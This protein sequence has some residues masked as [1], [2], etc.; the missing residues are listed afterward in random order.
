M[1][2]QTGAQFF[3]FVWIR[4]VLYGLIDVLY[5]LI[6]ISFCIM[7]HNTFSF[8]IFAYFQLFFY[9]C[10]HEKDFVFYHFV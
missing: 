2:G 7:L 10:D 9:L 5:E 4:D 1:S 8:Q 3:C 6:D